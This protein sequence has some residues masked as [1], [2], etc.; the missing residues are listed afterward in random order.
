MTE[1]KFIVGFCP[2]CDKAD[3]EGRGKERY[4][5]RWIPDGERTFVTHADDPTR[6][7]CTKCGFNKRIKKLKE[8][9]E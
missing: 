1:Q 8:K 6:L 9:G 4:Y 5:D 3:K 7:I 2:L